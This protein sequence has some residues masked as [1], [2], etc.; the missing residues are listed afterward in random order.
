MLLGWCH[1]PAAVIFNA[2]GLNW[3]LPIPLF[4]VP[5]LLRSMKHFGTLGEGEPLKAKWCTTQLWILIL[6]EWIS[7]LRINTVMTAMKT[8]S[9]WKMNA[10]Q[11]NNDLVT[12]ESFG[13]AV[14]EIFPS[15]RLWSYATQ[16]NFMEMQ[17]TPR[18]ERKE[19][20]NVKKNQN[21]WQKQS[22]PSLI[23]AVGQ[24]RLKARGKEAC[25]KNKEE[26]VRESKES[27]RKRR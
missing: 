2:I 20:E 5:K 4:Q 18:K 13:M 19:V 1:Q 23:A 7:C 11:H 21:G 27:S 15:L 3:K 26:R 24:K 8:S 25:Q 14:M 12:F 9:S 6:K 16:L 17:R 10:E 22:A